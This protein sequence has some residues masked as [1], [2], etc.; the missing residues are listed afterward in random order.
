L[1]HTFHQ[2]TISKTFETLSFMNISLSGNAILSPT[3][4]QTAIAEHYANLSDT[5]QSVADF[6]IDN[7]FAVATRSLRS[8]AQ[9]SKLSPS[10]FSRLARAIGFP[11]YEALREQARKE[12]ASSANRIS[13]KAKQLHDD[14]ELPLL[15]RQ[16]KACVSNIQALLT[17][18]T[19]QELEDT[20]DS[21]AAARNVII[22]GALGS[23]GF[24]DYFSYLTSWFDG[25]WS[26]AGRNGVTLASSLTRINKQDVLIVISKSPYA[27]RSVMAAEIAAEHGAT[28]IVITDRHTFPGI[29][30]AQHVFIQQIES[31]QFFAS[32]AATI[33][34]IET[35]SGMLLARAGAHAVNEIQQVIEQNRRLDEFSNPL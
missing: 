20:V 13:D 6:I 25:N 22:V 18:I 29:K 9:E 14:A 2:L 21:L 19:S 15:P 30:H 12:L 33:V 4:L 26:V 27:K 34:L 28:V 7:G 16:V 23:A 17:D 35:L 32:Y 10:S 3:S 1:K 5:L 11:D 8:V 31:P 24:A